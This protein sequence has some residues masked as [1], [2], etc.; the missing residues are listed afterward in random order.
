M[1]PAMLVH[2]LPFEEQL[3]Q[4]AEVI[5]S[6]VIGWDTDRVSFSIALPTGSLM[7]TS[8]ET[9][10]PLSSNRRYYPLGTGIH[11]CSLVGSGGLQGPLPGKEA[12]RGAS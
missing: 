12:W 1:I 9:V 10:I 11:R 4:G 5:S 6:K 8:A 7:K 2:R 3:F